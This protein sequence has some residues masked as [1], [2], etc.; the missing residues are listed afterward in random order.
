[1][2][3]AGPA[4]IR[5]GDDFIDP[6]LIEPFVA[7]VP[8]QNFHV[9]SDRTVR[10][11]LLCLRIGDLFRGAKMFDSSWIHGPLLAL[12]ERLAQVRKI[13]EGG[14][15]VNAHLFQLISGGGEIELTFQVMY[16]GLKERLAV[17]CTP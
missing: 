13:G 15:G 3:R 7:V 14:H 11:E 6:G 9:R 8:L 12:R 16:A 1:M 10:Q 17:Q 4:R 2:G 5:R